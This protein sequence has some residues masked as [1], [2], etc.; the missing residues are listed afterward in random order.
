MATIERAT[1][2]APSLIT[3]RPS[4]IEPEIYIAYNA[5][6]N[7]LHGKGDN[8]RA[9]ADYTEAIRLDPKYANAYNN[10]GVS[11]Q[12]DKGDYDRAIADY[13]EAIRL[14]PKRRMPIHQP[15]QCLPQQG[16]L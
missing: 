13:N 14:D 3:T 6:G 11:L 1:T 10:R 15:R 12:A 4:G 9:I 5:R 7:C 16:R 8:D 2:T